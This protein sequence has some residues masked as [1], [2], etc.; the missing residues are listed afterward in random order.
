MN[1]RMPF[2]QPI[3]I[4]L[5]AA[6][7]KILKI[8]IMS[9]DYVLNLNCNLL[10]KQKSILVCYM[11]SS[12]FQSVEKNVTH[13]NKLRHIQILKCLFDEDFNIDVC[14]C[15]CP[16]LPQEIMEKNYDYILGFG[17]SYVQACHAHPEA[18]KILFITENHPETVKRKYAERLKYYKHRHPGTKPGTL[19]IPRCGFYTPQMFD[20]SDYW[21]IMSN[22]YNFP[23]EKCPPRKYFFINGNGLYNSNFKLGFKNFSSARKHFLWL[24]SNGL[25]HKGLDILLDL[26]STMP[27]LTLHIYGVPAAEN[28]LLC[29]FDVPNIILHD[30]IDILSEKFLTEVVA[31][32]AFVI[33]LS[34]SEGM[35]SGVITAMR[36]GLIPL[37]TP[38]SGLPHNDTIIEFPDYKL[39]TVKEI[40]RR[41]SEYPEDQ[42]QKMAEQVYQCANR[43]FSIKNFNI[44]FHEIIRNMT[45]KLFNE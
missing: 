12:L 7:I 14:R 6:A 31:Q 37:V 8:Q 43:E 9:S 34:C 18:L 13:P 35:T 42:L 17:S 32:N 27:E 24:G 39:E 28:H 16:S 26:F 33:S 23:P 15:N 3:I 41:V 40:I 44:H 4:A 25:I 20:I 22:A 45:Q 38:E 29:S 19:A 30:R 2:L 5:R 36:H 1:C 10:R 11:A 21:I